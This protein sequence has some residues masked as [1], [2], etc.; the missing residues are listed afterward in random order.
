MHRLAALSLFV[1]V[2]TSAFA[3]RSD[4]KA[5]AKRHFDA[6]VSLLKAE[7]YEGAALSFEASLKLYPTKTALFN[8]A[9]CYKALK[10]WDEALAALFRLRRDFAGRLGEEM[11]AETAAIEK[12]IRNLVGTLTVEVDRPGAAVVVD[13]REVGTSPLAKVLLLAPGNHEVTARLSGA[14]YGVEKVLL[15]SGDDKRVSLKVA[16]PASPLSA[17]ASAKADKPTAKA[18]K[19]TAKADKPTAKADKPTA[20]ADKPT[21]KTDERPDPVVDQGSDP[22]AAEGEPSP[23]KRPSALFWGAA[24]GAVA[25]GV[26]SGVFFGLRGK[27]EGAYDDALQDWDALSP[28]LQASSAGGALLDDM[29][30]AAGDYDKFNGAGIGMAVAAGALTAAAVIILIVDMKSGEEAPGENAARSRFRPGFGGLSIDF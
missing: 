11:E 2:L 3:A 14:K 18:D 30:D 7:D 10:R 6:G 1:V 25:T 8:L 12:E 26:L 27:A 16:A 9:N 15:L 29:R 5:D 4:A 21:A 19:P 24:G 13:G 22:V 17:V 23:G 28:E 20:K